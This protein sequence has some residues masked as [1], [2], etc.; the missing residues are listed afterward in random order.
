MAPSLY[1]HLRD[2]VCAEHPDSFENAFRHL[3]QLARHFVSQR[4]WRTWASDFRRHEDREALTA[5]ACVDPDAFLAL[6]TPPAEES[7]PA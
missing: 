6:A 2:R 7:I 1:T 5:L 3:C 4:R